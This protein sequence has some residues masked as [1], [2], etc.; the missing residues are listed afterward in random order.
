[1]SRCTLFVG[2]LIVTGADTNERSSPP[3]G[4][5]IGG[6]IKYLI[7]ASSYAAIADQIKLREASW[8]LNWFFEVLFLVDEMLPDP[9]SRLIV[10]QFK[11]SNE[12]I[13]MDVVASGLSER[14]IGSGDNRQ[15]STEEL[16]HFLT[17]TRSFASDLICTSLRDPLE[18]LRLSLSMFM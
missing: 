3:R 14:L 7:V 13:M 12:D 10:D 17:D 5:L 11:S 6:T 1:M 8:L 2:D 15:R 4:D 16:H 9:P 18:D